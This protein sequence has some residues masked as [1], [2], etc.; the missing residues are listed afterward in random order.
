M[1]EGGSPLNSPLLEALIEDE[2]PLALL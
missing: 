1:G 2:A